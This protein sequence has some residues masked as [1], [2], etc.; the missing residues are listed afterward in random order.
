MDLVEQQHRGGAG[1][2]ESATSALGCL[3][4]VLDTGADS[5]EGLELRAHGIR[6]EAG[7]G[8]LARPGWSPKDDGDELA[9]LDE[10]AQRALRSKEV[11]LTDDIIQGGRA[12]PAGPRAA[13]SQG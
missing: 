11:I 12:Q 8:G 13:G 10:G 7:D 5:A 9:S 1:L 2:S 6:E 4:D 3:P